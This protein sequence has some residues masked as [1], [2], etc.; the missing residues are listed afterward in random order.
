MRVFVDTNIWLDVVLMRAG[1]ADVAAFLLLCAA[2]NDELWTAWHS[3][4]NIDYI[5]GRAKQTATQR[6]QHLRDLLRQSRVPA[7]DEHDAL[8]ALGL[9]WTDFED[10]LQYAAARRVQADVIIT[11]NARHFPGA[12]IPVLTPAEFLTRHP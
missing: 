3:L 8:F 10:A 6:E 2:R 11:G 5:L 7:T 4:S 1:Q 12:S 9:G